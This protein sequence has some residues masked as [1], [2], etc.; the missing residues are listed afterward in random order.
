MKYLLAILLVLTFGLSACGGS[1]GGGTTNPPDTGSPDN[2]DDGDTPDDGN[3]TDD[4]VPTGTAE[5]GRYGI[6]NVTKGLVGNVVVP[7]ATF[8]AYSETIIVPNSINFDEDSCTVEKSDENPDLPFMSAA[9]VPQRGPGVNV[10]GIDAGDTLTLSSG[11]DVY[12]TLTGGSSGYSKP[13]SREPLADPPRS[14]SMSIPGT[15][16]G[17]PAFASSTFPT[18]P[19]DYDLSVSD[20]DVKNVNAN[21]TFTWTGETSS[22]AYFWF[23]GAGRN[24]DGES[25]TFACFAKDDGSFTFPSA[26]QSELAAAGLVNG[27][28]LYSVRDARSRIIQGKTALDLSVAFYEGY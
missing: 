11:T 20:G 9:F 26:T 24:E 5:I 15:A 12:T 17:Y 19:G 7:V 4:G 23:A 1:D 28:L 14:L 25:V 6:A 22:D 21:T 13:Y 3:D 10:E 16:N 18:V 8:A 2:P 27:E